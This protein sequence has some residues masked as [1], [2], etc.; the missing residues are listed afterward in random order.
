MEKKI[1]ALI[2]LTAL[3]VFKSS[4]QVLDERVQALKNS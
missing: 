4:A 2:A 1:V 3:F